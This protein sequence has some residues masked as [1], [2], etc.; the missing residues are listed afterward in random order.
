MDQFKPSEPKI[1]MQSSK[2]FVLK[3]TPSLPQSTAVFFMLLLTLP[4]ITAC[5]KDEKD[6]KEDPIAGTI[7]ELIANTFLC[8]LK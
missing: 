5:S 8:K 4:F 2:S 1:R 7:Q 6:N 3:S